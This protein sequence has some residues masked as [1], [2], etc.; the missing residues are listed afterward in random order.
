MFGEGS[1]GN[2][3]LRGH[4]DGLRRD[5][6]RSR[7]QLIAGGKKWG[8][9]GTAAPKSLD[10][11]RGFHVRK[12]CALKIDRCQSIIMS[13]VNTSHPKRYGRNQVE[14]VYHAPRLNL[15]SRQRLRLHVR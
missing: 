8:L 1:E 6:V 11:T 13:S 4:V 10:G 5:R 3:R 12:Q 7:Q 2:E 14:Q 15:A 9:S